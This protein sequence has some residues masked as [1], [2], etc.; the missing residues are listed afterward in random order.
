MS[1]KNLLQEYCVKNAIPLP[2]YTARSMGR[3]HA[4]LWE[5]TVVV[6]NE[7]FTSTYFP[8]KTCAQQNAAK[9]AYDSLLNN[10]L[11]EIVIHVPPTWI[12]LIDLENSQSEILANKPILYY[13]FK[14]EFSTVDTNKYKSVNTHVISTASAVAN[15]ADHLMSYYA[16]QL[17]KTNSITNYIILSR[18]KS[19]AN[20]A[21][22]L[23]ND[24]YIVKHFKEPAAFSDYIK[25]L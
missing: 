1:Y 11:K 2:T 8:T 6:N 21:I 17:T 15:A 14:S 19:L 3:P 25:T 7:S 10:M 24:G 9:A 23:T 13:L 18:D 20:L 16:G 22:M 5:S 4:Q 12:A